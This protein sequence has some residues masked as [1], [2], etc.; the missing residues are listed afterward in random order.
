MP[1]YPDD[2]AARLA[3]A[4]PRDTVR[5]AIFNAAFDLIVELAGKPAAAECDPAGSGRRHEFFSYP[6]TDYLRLAWR[7]AELLSPR[8]GDRDGVFRELGS[9]ASRRWLCSSL[10]RTLVAFAGRDPRRL[11]LNTANGYR[12]VVSYG[13]RTI[14]WMHEREARLLFLHDFLV[15]PFHCGVLAAALEVTC[16]IP[17]RAE[18]HEI[19][20][21]DSEYD[22]TW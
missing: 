7:A 4:T 9:R 3:A 20:F 13:T 12:N 10:G 11:L 22:V 5:G 8:L 1:D 2:L 18:G 6:V 17:V 19:A 14:E 15:P 21:L 16:G